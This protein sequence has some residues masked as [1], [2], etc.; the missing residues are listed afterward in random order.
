MKF[1]Y[2]DW[3]YEFWKPLITPDIDYTGFY[4]ISNWGR[5][6]SIDRYVNSK[7]V[8]GKMLRR[9]R[10]IQPHKVRDYLRVG[11]TMNNIK[12]HYLVASLVAW[13]FPEIC[14]KWF[15]GAQ[16]NHKIEFEKDNNCTWNLEVCDAK[17][18]IN[19]GTR[20]ERASKSNINNAAFSVPVKMLSLKGEEIQVF[21]S[22]AEAARFINKNHRHIVDCCQGSRNSAYGYKWEYKKRPD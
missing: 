11:L 12:K 18:N 5:V 17:Y 14:G 8:Q 1:N 13:N 19:Y 15:E 22:V 16:V 6:R 4:E 10:I 21:P 2:L 20:T 3:L 9:G 7:P